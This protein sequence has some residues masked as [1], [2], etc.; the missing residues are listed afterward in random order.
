MLGVWR[1]LLPLAGAA[2]PPPVAHP[3]HTAVAEI[4]YN[5]GSR[6]AEIHIRVFADDFAA[7]V[8]VAPGARGA[9]SAMAGYVRRT[10]SLADQAGRV[11]R[12]QWRG[13]ERA[14]DVVLLRLA[15]P[16]P[17]GL[18]GARVRS[19]L[20]CE[21]FADQVNVVRALYGGRPVTLLFTPGDGAKTLP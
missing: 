4:T 12:L 21:R 20:L 19:V 3:L 14:G 11:L 16:V 15:V 5:G 18:S 17:A 9:E 1:V 8:G 10:F 6:T 2:T 13:A 7:A